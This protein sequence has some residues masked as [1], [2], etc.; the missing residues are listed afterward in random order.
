MPVVLGIDA[1]WTLKQPSGVA[2]VSK[3][4]TVW[5]LVAASPSYQHFYIQAVGGQRMEGRPLGA[6]P[7]VSSL[8][9]SSSRLCGQPVDLVAI[10]M[11]LSHSPIKGRRVSDN[12]VSKAYGAKKCATH[13]PSAAL[14]GPI[15]DEL[16][17]EF[18]RAGYPLQTDLISPPGLI[19]VYP[20]P[21]LVELAKAPERLR[22]K[23][24]KARNYW[25]NFAPSERR[26]F[27][28]REWARIIILLEDHL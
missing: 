24:S 13:S 17:E 11:P 15:S 18:G 5:R 4:D 6:R 10:D 12:V 28:L 25:P 7:D 2:L 27:L 9:V 23:V 8:L 14:P 1:A 26:T 22:Y 3:D 20:H 16:R 19:E 21:A